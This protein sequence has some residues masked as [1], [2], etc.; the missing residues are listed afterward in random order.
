MRLVSLE[1]RL[2]SLETHLVSLETHLVSLET[3]LVSLE[4]RANTEVPLRGHL[5]STFAL[6]ASCARIVTD[7]VVKKKLSSHSS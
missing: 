4:T 3:R 1:T 7:F 6:R 5:H 2:V